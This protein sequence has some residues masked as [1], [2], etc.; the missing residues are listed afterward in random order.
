MNNAATLLVGLL[1]TQ[2]V[3]LPVAGHLPVQDTPKTLNETREDV[4]ERTLQVRG[5]EY[6]LR[7]NTSN[8]TV[9]VF[10]EHFA[11]NE[12]NAR[13]SVSL[14]ERTVITQ[15]WNATGG[16]T[17]R[18]QTSLIYQYDASERVRNITLDT[19]Y[20]SVSLSYNFTV[21]RTY[22]GQYLRPTV[23]DVAFDRINDSHG[24]VTVTVRSDSLYRYPAYVRV[25]APGVKGK[26]LYLHVGGDEN[27]SVD[28][29]EVPVEEGEV[30]EGELRMHSEG[31]NESG[32]LHAQ[33]EYYGQP[34]QEQFEQVPYEPLELE[35]V[36][37]YSY[38]NE[39]R[40]TESSDGV[41]GGGQYR[42]L[43]GVL[44]GLSF[45]VVLVGVLV[46]RRRQV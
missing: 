10:A 2:S 35:E 32:P 4:V 15:G 7:V 9:S 28:S 6:Q 39:S 13:Y 12:T 33:W 30:F 24:Q 19:Y 16:E 1:L 8:H 5:T 23:T 29:I 20:G 46:A 45:F 22:E 37:E 43:I 14:N 41:F 31:L 3:I 36:E 26:V 17:K 18:S 21:P 25:W 34:G 44:A 27:V 11:N 38:Q 42:M 40:A